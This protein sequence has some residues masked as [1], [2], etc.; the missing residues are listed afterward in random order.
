MEKFGGEFKDFQFLHILS[1][2]FA[3]SPDTAYKVKGQRV[4]ERHEMLE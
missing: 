3:Y 4:A 2:C 1:S